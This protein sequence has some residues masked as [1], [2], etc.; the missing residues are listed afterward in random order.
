[1]PKKPISAKQLAANRANAARSTG[2]TTPQGKARSAQNAPK[3]GFTASTFAVVRLED[4]QEI[5]HLKN[6]L[7]A[8]DQPVTRRR[9]SPSS[10]SPL[11]SRA[12]CAPRA[13]SRASSPLASTKP[14]TN[15][16]V[17]SLR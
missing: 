4:L 14:S 1:M 12:F 15:V 3:H 5:A 8:V 11:P 13:S 9:S 6:D 17:P 2:P 7:M 10:A 16:E